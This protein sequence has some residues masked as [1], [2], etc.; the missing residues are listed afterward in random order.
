[1]A[2]KQLLESESGQTEVPDLAACYRLLAKDRQSLINTGS[3]EGEPL[4]ASV[5]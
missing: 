3:I 2:Q 5:I 4:A 1:L